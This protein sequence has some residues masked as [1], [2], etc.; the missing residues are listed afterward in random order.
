VK[1]LLSEDEWERTKRLV[2]EFARTDGPSLHAEL[3]QLARDAPTSWLEGFWDTMYLEYRDPS[4]I[5]VNPAFALNPDPS[6]ENEP[7]DWIQL[8]RAAKLL[9]ATAWFVAVLRSGKLTPDT[10]GAPPNQ[11]PLCMT[12]YGKL[13]GTCRIPIAGRDIVIS[14]HTARHA[15]VVSC[16]R[17]YAI[18]ILDDDN[19]PI[20]PSKLLNQLAALR[21]DS[22]LPAPT[23]CSPA[24]LGA[25]TCEH[26]DAWS[27]VYPAVYE[28][29]KE[30]MDTLQSSVILVCLDGPSGATGGEHDLDALCVSALHNY[31]QNRYVATM[32]NTQITFSN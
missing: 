18:D 9:H 21:A 14:S 15:C 13:F 31:G 5:N 29:N 2:D 24:N 12:Q 10:I 27:A 8:L 30:N 25:F 1:P 32:P 26:R 20:P 19:T 28:L 4:P 7:S 3:Q 11:I 17:F 22:L 6:L 16:N 23:G